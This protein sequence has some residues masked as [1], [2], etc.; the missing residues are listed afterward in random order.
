MKVI[1][2]EVLGTKTQTVYK[3]REGISGL[4]CPACAGQH[5]AHTK[6]PPCKF[7]PAG[8]GQQPGTAPAAKPRV[9]AKQASA[10]PVACAPAPVV[11]PQEQSAKRD[12]LEPSAAPAAE[13]PP[14]VAPANEAPHVTEVP[15]GGYMPAEL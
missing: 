12:M 15:Q 7:A 2:E 6:I 11:P 5:R 1:A 10:E 3:K 14:P 8:D 9:P 4:P 13:E